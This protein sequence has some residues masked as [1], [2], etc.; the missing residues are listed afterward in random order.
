M[1]F[2]DFVGIIEPV[3]YLVLTI[4]VIYALIKAGMLA[5]KLI[6]WVGSLFEDEESS[7]EVNDD[8]DEEEEGE[9]NDE[10]WSE[11][12][13]EDEDGD[14]DEDDNSE[15]EPTPNKP[16]AKL[17][18]GNEYSCKFCSTTFKYNGEASCPSCKAPVSNS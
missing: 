17:L 18:I 6:H 4:V 7:D 13:D 11:D 3:F 14:E 8:E 10:F 15:V 12:E 1:G 9:E 2:K 16:N 5:I